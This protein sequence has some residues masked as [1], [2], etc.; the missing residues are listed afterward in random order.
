MGLEVHSCAWKCPGF[1]VCELW[2][3]GE[4]GGP[5]ALNQAFCVTD[6]T[7][8]LCS[9]HVEVSGLI[10]K[11]EVMYF[12][13]LAPLFLFCMADQPSCNL[14]LWFHASVA[15]AG[16]GEKASGGDFV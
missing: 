7:E 15:R 10:L 4:T 5:K 16:R 13:F 6:A 12:S 2:S 3:A 14:H 9:S 1:F 8:L 11:L